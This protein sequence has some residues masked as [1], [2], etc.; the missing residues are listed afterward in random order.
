MVLQLYLNILQVPNSLVSLDVLIHPTQ[1]TTHVL[2]FQS[3][4]LPTGLL[5]LALRSGGNLMAIFLLL[6]PL[7]LQLPPRADPKNKYAFYLDGAIFLKCFSPP[8]M[9]L[10]PHLF[11]LS[12]GQLQPREI[13]SIHHNPYTIN[14]ILCSSQKI[15]NPSSAN[16]RERG[17]RGDDHGIAKY[18]VT[19]SKKFFLHTSKC[20][21]I[22][23]KEILKYFGSHSIPKCCIEHKSI[24]EEP[25]FRQCVAYAHCLPNRVYG[26]FRSDTDALVDEG[27][28]ALNET[29]IEMG[30]RGDADE[31]TRDIQVVA[32]MLGMGS[33]NYGLIP[34]VEADFPPSFPTVVQ[35]HDQFWM[36]S[37]T[38][39]SSDGDYLSDTQSQSFIYFESES[40]S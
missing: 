1:P 10:F 32:Q 34:Q 33:G 13:V 37:E 8:P 26:I 11:H 36:E 25:W 2:K 29:E 3:I 16:S 14:N 5:P 22:I 4:L 31:D 28:R 7:L 19:P 9:P 39:I 15:F 20:S 6:V 27:Y 30:C 35:A 38:T 18:A 40:E 12:T 21:C 17:I 24:R 23:Q